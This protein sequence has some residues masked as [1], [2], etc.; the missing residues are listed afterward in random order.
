VTRSV[1]LVSNRG[2]TGVSRFLQGSSWCAFYPPFHGLPFST[3]ASRDGP[4]DLQPFL[5]LTVVHRSSLLLTLSD[6]EQ[7]NPWASAQSHVGIS[8]TPQTEQP[9][10]SAGEQ[11]GHWLR[12]DWIEEQPNWRNKG[13][14]SF[15]FPSATRKGIEQAEGDDTMYFPADGER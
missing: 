1:S 5:R 3:A 15:F 9:L 6:R 13:A 8:K 10:S 12:R 11:T 7:P 2:V 14:E 4:R